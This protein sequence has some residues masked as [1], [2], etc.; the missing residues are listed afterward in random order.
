[1]DERLTEEIAMN[2]PTITMERDAALQKLQQYEEAARQNPRAYQGI[3]K[4]LMEG[5]RALAKGKHLVDVNEAL[6]VGGLNLAGQP[7]LAICRAHLTSV[8]WCP[9]GA[10]VGDRSS[11]WISMDNSRRGHGVFDYSVRERGVDSRSSDIRAFW[12]VP[13][14][15]FDSE[16]LAAGKMFRA[17]CPLIPLPLR[18]KFKLENYFLLW[19]ANWHPEPP[20]DPYLLKPLTG[21]LMEIIAE[22]E[23]TPLEIAAVRG[24]MR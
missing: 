8:L 13:A 17:Y 3:D 9:H 20:R 2:S 18:P 15:T 16:K 12:S 6:K 1:M 7:K 5:Y 14:G 11:F 22:W 4:E 10:I 23:L 19:E 21:S 24:A